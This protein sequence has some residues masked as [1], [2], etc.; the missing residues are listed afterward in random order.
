[1]MLER[2][3]P[4]SRRRD[5]QRAGPPSVTFQVAFVDKTV[6]CM[7]VWNGEFGRAV[8]LARIAYESRKRCP[9]PD[10]L[11]MHYVQNDGTPVFLHG[12]DLAFMLILA[13]ELDNEPW[14][15]KR[16]NGATDVKM[17]RLPDA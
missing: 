5:R 13:G 17:P 2:P 9:P 12:F 10:I 16:Q 11:A 7:T 3:S 6:T 4:Q 15:R 14:Y 1:M 8:R